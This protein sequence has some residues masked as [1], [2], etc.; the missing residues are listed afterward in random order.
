MLIRGSVRDELKLNPVVMSEQSGNKRLRGVMRSN[1]PMSKHTSWRTGGSADRFYVPADLEDLSLFLSKQS[2]YETCIWLGLGS[3]IL[4][5]DGGIR[6][7]VIAITGVL[8]E[9]E[10]CDLRTIKAGAGITCAKFA[11]F[12]AKSGLTGVEFLAGIPGTIGGALAMNAGAFGGEIWDCVKN[13]ETINRI[14]EIKSR[15]R[16]EFEIAYRSVNLADDEWF[17]AAEF[18]LKFD[19]EK[20]AHTRIREYLS[21]RTETQPTGESSCGSVFRNPTG[22][23]AARLI[24]VCGLKGM[25]IGTA[26]VSEKHANFIINDGGA[27]A[28]EIETLIKYIQ[29]IVKEKTGTDLET[30]V[31]IIGEHLDY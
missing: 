15:P 6:G 21:I 12:A 19:V 8:N 20:K 3:N 30:E 29:K 16:D 2:A 22:D 27:S 1:E 11:R 7:T 17:I 14:G 26:C 25:R 18:Q 13:T 28:A 9:I 5:R 23:H 24:D 10:M 31:R 4:V